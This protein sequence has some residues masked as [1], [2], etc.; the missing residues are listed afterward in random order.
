MENQEGKRTY[1][2]GK[3]MLRHRLPILA[4]ILIATIFFGYHASKVSLKNPTIDLFPKNHPYV[5]TYVQYEDIF[6]GAN[7]VIIAIEAK[8][9]SIFQTEMLKKIKTISKALELVPAVNNYQ[10][11]SLAQRKIKKTKVEDVEGYK[12]DPIMWPDIPE[13]EEE[14][15]ELQR[16]VYTTGRI[17]GS[18]VSLDDK[19][20]LI[21]AGFFE[22]GLVSPA[23]PLREVVRAMALADQQDPDEAIRIISNVA[24]DAVWTLDDT[25]YDAIDKI[26][27]QVED[28]NTNTYMIG[29]P[30]LLGQIYK[31]FP[32]LYIIFMLTVL[33]IVGVLFLYFRDIRGVA[34]PVITALISAVWG[35]GFL[36]FLGY[37]F[38]PLVIVVP[39]IISARALSH[40]VQLIERYMEEFEIHADRMEASARTF[41][42]LFKPGMLSIITD[43]AG[44]FIVI[45]TP[46]PLMEKLAL[47]G[48]FWVL[49]I[50]VSDVIFNPIFLSYFPPPKI[51]KTKHNSLQ[52][53]LLRAVG[54]WTYGKQRV[55]ILIGTVVL[56]VFGAFFASNLVIGDVHPGTPMLWPD[57]DYNMDT[58]KVGEMFGNTEIMS[59]I[60][61]GETKNAIK[62]PTVLR[63][64]EALQRHLEE[65]PEVAST[66]SIADLV[67]E[68]TKIMHGGNPKWELIPEAPRESGFYLE[69]IF[70]GAEPGDLAR[71]ITNDFKD[72]NI[73]VYLMDHRGETLRTVVAAAR[74]FI[75]N[76]PME[77]A[78]FRLAG[79]YGG[80]LAAV[81]EAIVSSEAKVT[82]M[83]FVL[84]FLFCGIAYRSALAGLFFLVPIGMSNYLTY[85]L[86]GALG[87]GLDVNALPVVAL[88]VGLGV[89]YGLYVLGRIEEEYA[90]HKDLNKATAKAIA[91]AGRAV[92]FTASTMVAG[93]IF[94][95][96]SFLR[97]Q[98]EMGILLAFWMIVS[99]IG[100]LLLLPTLVVT[101][102][103]KFI[104]KGR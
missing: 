84:I 43:A 26:V 28:D 62:D 101:F 104:T 48:S 3:W 33:S 29:R 103:P 85:A 49:S 83:A 24:G 75:E 18:L 100:G 55:P 65:L 98:A 27:T 60:V 36:G 7:I 54:H 17:H 63:N 47:M 45:L 10:V 68:I 51:A 67:P 30:I 56:F 91:T 19:A 40:S 20:A 11:L 35:L 80:L 2:F 21:V 31:N 79:N 44:V 12:S 38:N 89:D 41:S 102:K 71:F 16:S 73:S 87:I 5:E 66:S 25:L 1:K 13:T 97:F 57:S 86:M 39:F 93:I 58:A 64:M 96:F 32:Q 76:H 90:V 6:G 46:I 72:A 70:S 34:I 95:A 15:A 59:I 74:D 22:K 77:G 52:D 99:M 82:I 42:G 4:V 61:E 69:M 50:I 92:L 8:Q 78:N 9:G 88:G 14:I 53:R 23:A 94:W 81:N 37:D